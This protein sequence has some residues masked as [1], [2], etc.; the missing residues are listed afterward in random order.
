MPGSLRMPSTE[1]NTM[2]KFVSS[3]LVLAFTVLAPLTGSAALFTQTTKCS[4]LDGDQL[5]VSDGQRTKC[6]ARPAE[7]TLSTSTEQTIDDMWC[8]EKSSI[9]VTKRGVIE[10]KGRACGPVN[11]VEFY[12]RNSHLFCTPVGDEESGMRIGN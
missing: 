10:K 2:R 5:C 12:R 8:V 11:S 1:G 3:I 6:F 7:Y 9:V 4:Y